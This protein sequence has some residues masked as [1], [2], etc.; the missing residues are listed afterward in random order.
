MY[1]DPHSQAITDPQ[2]LYDT[3][4]FYKEFASAPP[5]RTCIINGVGRRSP[6]PTTNHSTPTP[7]S[8]L[9]FCRRARAC[10]GS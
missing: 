9:F 5:P 1:T 4:L 10:G 7:L 2:F 6:P 8:W 3:P